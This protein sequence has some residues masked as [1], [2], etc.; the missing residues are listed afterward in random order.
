MS[1]FSQ[2]IQPFS[3]QLKQIQIPALSIAQYPK[4]YLQLLLQNQPYYLH[5]Y[6]QVLERLMETSLLVKEEIRLV[7]FGAGNGLLGM[8]ARF[9]GIK[10]V[11][12]ADVSQPFMN[13]ARQVA[14]QLQIDIQGFIEGDI[15]TVKHHFYMENKPNA[16]V[17]T[18][19]I[20]HIYNLDHFFETIKEIDPAIVSVF[21]TAS[22]TANWFK[23]RQLMRLQ[24][25]D[26]HIGSNAAHALQGNEF[27]GMAFFDIRKRIIHHHHPKLSSDALETLAAATR[28]MNKQD[29][30][31]SIE[32]FIEHGSVPFA[33]IHATNTCDPIT[34]SWT[35]RLLT[36]EEYDNIYKKAGFSLYF[37]NGFYNQWQGGKKSIFLKAANTLISLAG[38]KGQ[39]I[40]PFITLTGAKK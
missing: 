38:T 4:V 2:Y 40:A 23:N 3:Q 36:A 39:T 30:L 9:C 21:T 10:N 6:A 15:E 34:G 20:E 22:V 32:R 13:A 25:H 33:P 37:T 28:G 12:M 14:Q 31:L 29:I 16:I 11:Y 5:I 19:V 35:E 8:F 26:E 1:H 24:H 27:A 18:D 17:G 7:D